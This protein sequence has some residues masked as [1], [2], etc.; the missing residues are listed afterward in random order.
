MS[1]IRLCPT[2]SNWGF[3]PLV[4][5]ARASPAGG[6]AGRE[7][8][9]AFSRGVCTTPRVMGRKSGGGGRQGSERGSS[10]PTVRVEGGT[11]P[12]LPGS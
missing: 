3:S 7:S 9:T 12:E 10:W 6:F 8:A 2:K 11:G 5:R 4:S 1:I